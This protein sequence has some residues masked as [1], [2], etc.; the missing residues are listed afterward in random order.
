MNIKVGH[1]PECDLRVAGQDDHPFSRFTC[2][3]LTTVAQDY[4]AVSRRAVRTLFDAI[5]AGDDTAPHETVL[6]EGKLIMRASA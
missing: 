3:P 5:D 4:D 1:E 6:F 2:P